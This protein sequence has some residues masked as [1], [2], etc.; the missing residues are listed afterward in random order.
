MAPEATERRRTH[1]IGIVMTTFAAASIGVGAG[2]CTSTSTPP[3][4]DPSGFSVIDD[5]RYLT[6]D[7]LEMTVD[8]FVPEA[9]G[10][11]PV[12]VAFHGRSSAFKDAGSNT[13]IAE[14]AAADGMLVFTPTW[15][16]GDPF[17]LGVGD[18]VDLRRAASC[19]VAFA[20]LW[21]TEL[22]GEADNTV[23]YGFSAGAAPALA[24]TVAPVGS[25][26]GCETDA[27]PLPVTGAVLGDGEYFYHSQAFDTAFAE[28]LSAMQ[29]E[30]A[31]LIDR[32]RWPDGLD[33]RVVVWAAEPGTAP[34]PVDDPTAP[35]WFG[36]RDPTGSLLRDLLRLDR[37]DDGIVDY[38]DAALLIESRLRE[39]GLDTDVQI[40]PGGHA[41]DDKV[42]PLVE[43]IRSVGATG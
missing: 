37:L 35:D 18:I 20:Q 28:D 23:V 39:A 25:V 5:R 43:A 10:P 17:P 2:A 12:V 6:I 19:A 7:G 15:I 14:R 26:P 36:A 30:V 38:V 32:D 11:W 27:A 13:V 29:S 40:F 31:Q 41:V 33:A 42:E 16:A 9:D 34:R 3:L 1:V 24:A 4:A 8:A 21:A 22:G